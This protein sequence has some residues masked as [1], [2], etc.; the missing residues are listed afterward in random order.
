[1]GK[2]MKSNLEKIKSTIE[3][4]NTDIN[5]QGGVKSQVIKKLTAALTTA[6]DFIEGLRQGN[7]TYP[8]MAADETFEAII[9]KLCNNT[10]DGGPEQS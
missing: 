7:H 1:M 3:V 4:L 2:N 10:A 5:L 8:K 6:C 9:A